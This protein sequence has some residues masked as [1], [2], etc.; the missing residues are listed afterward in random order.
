M[1]LVGKLHCRAYCIRPGRF[2]L[3][4]LIDAAGCLRHLDSLIPLGPEFHADLAMWRELLE[5]PELKASSYR[6]H[7][8]LQPPPP[9]PGG[10]RRR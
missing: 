10:P 2:F 5:D 8:P 7:S 4:R 1:S 6:T 9:H 3:R